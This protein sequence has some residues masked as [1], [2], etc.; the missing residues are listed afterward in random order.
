L[1]VLELDSKPEKEVLGVMCEVGKKLVDEGADVLTLGCAGMTNMKATVE[2]AV[3]RDVHVVDGVLVGVQHLAGLSRLGM[4][5]AKRGMYASS[6]SD[7]E[8]R[9]QNWY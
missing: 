3:G 9:G 7:R 2:E 5:T 6:A 1:G 8:R 4:R